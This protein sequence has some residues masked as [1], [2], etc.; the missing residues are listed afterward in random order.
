M[1]ACAIAPKP[2]SF[3]EIVG[4]YELSAAYSPRAAEIAGLRALPAV[5]AL[6]SAQADESEQLIRTPRSWRLEGGREN[7]AAWT[8]SHRDRP[9]PEEVTVRFLGWAGE[10]WARL[11]PTAAGFAG[12]GYAVARQHGPREPVR[13]TLTRT[14]CPTTA[15][16]P[17]N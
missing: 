5:I 9:G 2:A 16:A 14:S 13:I 11:Q 4:C 15:E 8:P 12:E 10:V 3:I 1:A 7:Y 17:S 6:D